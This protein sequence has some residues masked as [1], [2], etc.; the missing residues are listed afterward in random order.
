MD[1]QFHFSPEL[2]DFRKEVRAF[3]EENALKE[4]LTHSQRTLLSPEMFEKGREST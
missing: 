4:P 3:I 1:F 2:E